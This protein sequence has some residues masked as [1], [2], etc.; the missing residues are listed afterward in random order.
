V[1]KAKTM[2]AT[3]HDIQRW[4]DTVNDAGRQLS[5]WE[6]GFMASITARVSEGGGLSVVQREV[7]E[8]LYGQK[9][10]T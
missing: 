5:A 8:W 4:I 10:P 1:Q 2:P 7:L 6:V 9:T 3:Q